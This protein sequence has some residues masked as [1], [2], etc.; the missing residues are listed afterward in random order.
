MVISDVLIVKGQVNKFA[1]YLDRIYKITTI[2][3]SLLDQKD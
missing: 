2:D 3:G 1:F